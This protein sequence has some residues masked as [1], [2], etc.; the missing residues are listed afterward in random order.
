MMDP[1]TRY[2]T[3]HELL[4]IVDA[5]D[6]VI[7]SKTRREIHQEGLRHRAVHILVFDSHGHLCLQ[8][9]SLSKDVNPGAWDTSAAG[10]VDFGED[11]ANAARRELSEELSIH[12]PEAFEAVGRIDACALTGWEFVQIF[13]CRYTGSITPN[14]EE[15]DLLKW[16]SRD[17][18]KRLL[19]EQPE[20]ITRSFRQ[21]WELFVAS[22][23]S[24]AFLAQ[25][26]D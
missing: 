1:E 23:L 4:A 22:E 15:I 20:T 18:L 10:H 21:V 9:R 25:D 12:R 24:P 7:G 11:Y 16:V 19:S 13:A 26:S 8:K 17:E 14:P 2:N 6:V 5:D 3:D